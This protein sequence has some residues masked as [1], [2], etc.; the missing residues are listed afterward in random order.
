MGGDALDKISRLASNAPL[1]SASHN[2]PASVLAGCDSYDDDLGIYEQTAVE[3]RRIIYLLLAD[4]T[5]SPFLS[6][7]QHRSNN[8]NQSSWQKLFRALLSSMAISDLPARDFIL[9][10]TTT[11]KV[12]LPI[13]FKVVTVSDI[14]D[15]IESISTHALV[16]NLM[17][18]GPSAYSCYTES[19]PIART[20]IGAEKASNIFDI[21]YLLLCTMPSSLGKSAQ[22]KAILQQNDF[23]VYESLKMIIVALKR[24]GRLL[25]DI[26][27][28]EGLDD[29]KGVLGAIEEAALQRLPD[30]QSLLSVRSKYDFYSGKNK[31]STEV[32]RVV[33]NLVLESLTL[34]GLYLSRSIDEVKFDWM[35]ILPPDVKTFYSIPEALQFQTL[36]TAKSMLFSDSVS[37]LNP[38]A[39]F[40]CFDD[41][42]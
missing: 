23:I 41:R 4:R 37:I 31:S 12:L 27:D 21:E 35:K 26:N 17:L 29:Q 8:K 19:Q 33:G 13:L 9:T 24:L 22:T 36:Y 5:N 7:T 6:S 42:I 14:Q 11:S 10:C 40:A 32:T 2:D 1:L 18:N 38:V 25:Q 39:N 30:V 20:H 3:A 15:T 34:Y 28:C 16:R